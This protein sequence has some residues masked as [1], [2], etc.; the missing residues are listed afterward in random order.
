[1]WF[2]ELMKKILILLVL[3]FST[4]FSSLAWGAENYD[5]CILENMKGAGSDVAA[6]AIKDACKAKQKKYNLFYLC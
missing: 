4:S 6:K 1:M 2:N 5:D 3:L